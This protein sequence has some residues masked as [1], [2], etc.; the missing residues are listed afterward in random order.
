[1]SKANTAEMYY[2]PAAIKG[3]KAPTMVTV[4]E[5]AAATRLPQGFLRNACND[6]TIAHIRS[7]S[8]IYINLDSLLSYLNGEGGKNGR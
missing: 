4:K 7:G 2:M 5:A 3:R 8:K 1:M 6:G